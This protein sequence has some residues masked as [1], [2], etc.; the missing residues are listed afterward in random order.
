MT[1]DL[2]AIDVLSE[3][4]EKQIDTLDRF[5]PHPHDPS[6]DRAV[7]LSDRDPIL[8]QGDKVLRMYEA[9]LAKAPDDADVKRS[10]ALH[11]YRMGWLQYE[12]IMPMYLNS[13]SGIVDSNKYADLTCYYMHRSFDMVANSGAASIL[14]DVFRMAGF[15]GTAIYWLKQAEGLSTDFGQADAATKAKARRL[16]LQADG[17][18][19]DPPLGRQRFPTLRTAGLLPQ[20]QSD[21]PR[22]SASPVS[23]TNTGSPYASNPPTQPYGQSL[24]TG[25]G[26]VN[27]TL[28][29]I[30]GILSVTCVFVLGPV[31]WIMGNNALANINS[32]GDQSQLS[33]VRIG[34]VCGIIGTVFLVL[35]TLSLLNHR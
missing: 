16:D 15:Y 34:R 25:T 13:K 8:A 4:F 22:P 30:L 12:A 26:A 2:E 9:E 10:L 20:G 35:A 21:Q 18:T 3:R 28:I 31:A 5:D 17:K 33:F 11:L 14:A 32:G 24:S 1:E 23:T 6:G 27:G 19:A 29:L 7:I